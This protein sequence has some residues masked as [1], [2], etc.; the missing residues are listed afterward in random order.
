M[1]NDK[2]LSAFYEIPDMLVHH[3]ERRTAITKR[4]KFRRAVK[5]EGDLVYYSSIFGGVI[6]V[7]K[8]FVSDGASVPQIF[9]NMFPPFGKYLESAVVHDMLCKAGKNGL[10]ICDSKTAHNI[11]D[12][13]LEVQGIP[14]LKRKTM[15]WSVKLLGPRFS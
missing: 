9:W 12:E 13:A 1:E 10:P 6:K 3:V 5:L 4:K 11:F 8:G 14:F 2:Q 7:S 15:A